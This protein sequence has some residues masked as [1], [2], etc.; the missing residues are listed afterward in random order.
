MKAEFLQKLEEGSSYLCHPNI[1]N[2]DTF[3]NEIKW[4]WNKD[5]FFKK[6]DTIAVCKAANK[7]WKNVSEW[8]QHSLANK[9]ETG[10]WQI[11]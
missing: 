2:S 9:G 10:V 7:T 6:G 8:V 11:K 4:Y 3:H 1:E 5:H